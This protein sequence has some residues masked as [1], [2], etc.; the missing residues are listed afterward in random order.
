MRI[1]VQQSP[2]TLPNG[3]PR[4]K[5]QKN[6]DKSKHVPKCSKALTKEVHIRSAAILYSKKTKIPRTPLERVKL[7]VCCICLLCSKHTDVAIFCQ[8]VA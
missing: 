7:H 2:K 1:H 5:E 6:I 4:P 3:Q 8:N